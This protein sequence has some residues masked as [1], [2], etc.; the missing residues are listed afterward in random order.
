M[1]ISRL[2]SATERSYDLPCLV[3]AEFGVIREHVVAIA[4]MAYSPR[5]VGLA[6]TMCRTVT[7]W[8]Y[9]EVEEHLKAGPQCRGA[10]AGGTD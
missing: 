3:C 9:D 2:E 4:I 10:M 5:A 1:A 8:T 6:C 7:L